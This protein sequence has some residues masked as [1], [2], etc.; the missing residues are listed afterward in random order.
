MEETA[1][2]Q[3]N[4]RFQ[5]RMRDVGFKQCE[6]ADKLNELLT[7]FGYPGTVSDR[8]VRQWLTGKTR[9]P[10]PRQ[11]RALEALFG[12]TAE[13]LGFVPPQGKCHVTSPPE[14]HVLRRT[15]FTATAGTTAAVVVPDLSPRRARVG[16]SDVIELRKG[17]DALMALDAHRGGHEALESAALSGARQAMD[18][19]QK[20]A[21]QRIRQR[22]F[23][24][25]ADYTATAAWSAIDARR[26]GRAEQYLDRALRLAGMAKDGIAQLRVWNSYAMLAH[27][28]HEYAKAVDAAYAAQAVGVA[29]RAPLY[30]SLA[31]ARAALGHATLH[32]RQAALRSL[33][34]AEEALAKADVQEPR[35][36]W[37]G[38]Y[39]LSELTAL[40][41]IV[42]DRIGDHADAEAASHRALSS[43]P[44]K[45]HRNRAL[46]T[47]RLALAQLHQR[48]TDQACVTASSAFDLM[49]GYPIPG[50]V[51]S[52]LGDFYRDLIAIA[53]T[54]PVAQDWGDRFR[55]EWSRA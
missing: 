19:Q 12:C 5:E 31:H 16:T 37:L 46:V 32:H 8:T 43:I 47:A 39:D 4:V 6:L 3:P 11:R 48:E 15:F 25:A 54:T 50:R 34:Y 41:A 10:H 38:F 44:R 35:P 55:S 33:G 29:R 28:R 42:R 22:L 36:S 24:A 49:S 30:A 13:E 1:P 53:P 21:T 52:L 23:S 7:D 51:R 40:T 27:Q 2:R 18:M 9:W 14:N 26:L 45:F 20:A 17:L